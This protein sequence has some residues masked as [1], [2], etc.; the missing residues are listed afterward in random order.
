MARQSETGAGLAANV[1]RLG[2]LDLPGAGQVTVRGRYAYVGHM[3]PPHGTTILD[4]S[5]PLR[6]RA[7]SSIALADP[8][9]H[10]H[11]VRVVGDLMIV[12]VEQNNRHL[13]RKGA[14]IPE[15]TA[16]LGTALGRVPADAELAAELQVAASDVPRLREAA[17]RGYRDGG[18]RIYDISDRS[19]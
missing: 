5:D 17:A 16:R 6:P 10:T 12:N 7:V 11:K 18:F 14:K 4:V 8:Y 1:R 3:R 13:L 9:S 15:A 2:H 19:R